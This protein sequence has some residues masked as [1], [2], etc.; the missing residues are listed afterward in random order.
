M[1]LT[2]AFG[3]HVMDEAL[4]GFLDLWNPLVARAKE[5]V[6]WLPLPSFT[7]PVWLAA[8]MAGV[9][10]LALLSPFAAVGDRFLRFVAYGYGIIMLFNGLGHIGASIYLGRLAPGV[11][12]A[13]LLLVCSGW[14]LVRLAR[15]SGPAERSLHP[16]HP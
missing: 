1:A 5:A 2:A 12:S 13:P 10:L 15:S 11:V 6:P 8:L 14:L 9:I 7:F 4:T 16:G 3:L